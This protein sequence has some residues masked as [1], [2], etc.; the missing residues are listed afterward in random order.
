M[1]LQDRAIF[2]RAVLGPVMYE[3]LLLTV[4]TKS[5]GFAGFCV[6]VVLF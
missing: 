2:A 6:L 4:G 5:T 3:E 1:T